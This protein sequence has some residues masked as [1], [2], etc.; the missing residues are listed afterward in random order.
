MR[1]GNGENLHLLAIQNQLRPQNTCSS[2]SANAS[3][4]AAAACTAEW[5]KQKEARP[6]KTGESKEEEEPGGTTQRSK[7]IYGK[8]EDEAR[9][10][11]MLGAAAASGITCTYTRTHKYNLHVHTC[12][13]E[14]SSLFKPR[15]RGIRGSRGV[16]GTTARLRRE[17]A[18]ALRLCLFLTHRCTRTHAHTSPWEF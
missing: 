10:R 1:H 11:V 3:I 15:G 17:V 12:I 8:E 13:R 9:G 6:G 16:R 4:A 5:K 18:R 2:A 14:P 7:E